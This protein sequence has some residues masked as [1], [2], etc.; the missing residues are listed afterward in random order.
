[1]SMPYSTSLTS[2]VTWP[3]NFTSPP[4]ARPW[5]GEPPQP[6]KKPVICQSASSPRQPGI[7]GSPC[8]V[9]FE[10]PQVRIDVEFGAHLAPIVAAAVGVDLGDAIEHQH[11]RQRQLGIAGTEQLAAPAGEQLVI[12]VGVLAIRHQRGSRLVM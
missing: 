9:A 7:T 4:S 8:E 3:V 6:R 5:P 12:G 1:M 2:L 10:E 11:G